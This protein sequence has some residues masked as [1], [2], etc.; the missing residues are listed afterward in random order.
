MKTK[1]KARGFEPT[2]P[3]P[4]WEQTKALM[5]PFE[6]LQA[7]VPSKTA[8]TLEMLAAASDAT[9]DE[10]VT[11]LLVQGLARV[12]RKLGELPHV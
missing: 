4:T 1:G 6:P 5:G 7:Q 12:A 8:R 9:V 10:L 3:E 2:T 11:T